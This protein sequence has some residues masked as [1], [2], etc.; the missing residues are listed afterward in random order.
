MTILDVDITFDPSARKTLRESCQRGGVVFE[1]VHRRKNGS[2]FPVE[3][4]MKP[5]TIDRAYNVAV[6]RDITDR[7]R[8]QEELRESE[9][10]LRLAAEA[11]RCSPI[12]GCGHRSHSALRGLQSSR[13]RSSNPLHRQGTAREG[14]SRRSASSGR[15]LRTPDARRAAFSSE[16]PRDPAWR[17]NRVGGTQQP[18][19]PRRARA[20][21][22]G[23]PAWRP[24]S[25][26][27]SE[28]KTPCPPSVAG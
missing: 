19:V 20:S 22:T 26:N 15:R 14:A 13:R 8:A 4:T 27:A 18:R 6:V 28:V 25:R 21:L 17:R 9:E 7:K 1:S 3:V 24:T 2:T 5:V 23:S 12:R 10:R 16:L 11:G